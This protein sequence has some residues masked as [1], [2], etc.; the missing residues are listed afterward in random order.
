[1]RHIYDFSIRATFNSRPK[2][3]CSN[4]I[5]RS[6]WLST[7]SSQLLSVRTYRSAQ[8][9]YT[10]STEWPYQCQTQHA[11]CPT[12]RLYQAMFRAIAPLAMAIL[13]AATQ[14]MISV[15]ITGYVTHRGTALYGDERVPTKTGRALIA[16]STVN[17]V[18]T[19]SSH[20]P[21]SKLTDNT[22]L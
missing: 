21:K 2:S 9:T 8:E 20:R 14:S 11:T 4:Q 19:R 1:M 3:I 6:L 5:S 16:R 22:S 15:S 10:S 7:L 18:G 12:G 13:T 17:R